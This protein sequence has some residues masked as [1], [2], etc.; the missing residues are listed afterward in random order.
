MVPG[1]KPVQQSLV[2]LGTRGLTYCVCVSGLFHLVAEKLHW[3]RRSRRQASG[4]LPR[5]GGCIC[6]HLAA[7]R[8]LVL[9]AGIE[10]RPQQCK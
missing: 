1:W 6:P 5:F 7:F 4:L 9:Q 2:E 8:I 3:K 10:L